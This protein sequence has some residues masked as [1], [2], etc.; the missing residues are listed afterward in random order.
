MPIYKKE[1]SNMRIDF[2]T[3]CF[4]DAIAP[5]AIAKLS[6][7]SGGLHPYTDGTVAGLRRSMA[8]GEVDLS[9]VMHIATNTGQQQKVNDF[10]ASIHNGR[11]IV[12]FGSVHPDAPDA[13]EELERIK[14]LG[15][16]GVKLHPD[17][18]GFR[19]DEERMKP[20][21][22]K[23]SSLGLITLFHAGYDYGFP[24]PYGGMPQAMATALRWFDSPV[25][26]AH[27]GGV[28]CAEEVLRHLCGTDIYFDTAFGYSMLPKYYA[29]K[30]LETHGTKRVLFGTDT[31]W[32]TP[33]MEMRLLDT[34]PLTESERE[35][36]CAGNA[37][38]LLG[39]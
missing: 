11:D 1:A 8:E 21:Y 32:H 34:L 22:K 20:I 7:A 16:P 10:A 19:V 6:Y 5:K 13:L 29:E 35:D 14:A 31:P 37:K 26:A 2:H 9:V 28:N 17:Y 30:I 4:P 27:W 15:L 39:L 25:I 18:Q 33:A 38:R 12:S 36:I 23:I 24:P 3:H